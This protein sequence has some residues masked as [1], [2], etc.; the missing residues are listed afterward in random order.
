MIDML[1]GAAL[2]VIG[3]IAADITYTIWYCRRVNKRIEEATK[4]FKNENLFMK[5]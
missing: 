5:E 1:I 2:A 4:K 3:F